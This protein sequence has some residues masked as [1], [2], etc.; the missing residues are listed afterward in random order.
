MAGKWD[1]SDGER[2][3]QTQARLDSDPTF[4]AAFQPVG[5]SAA[6][7]RD[8]QLTTAYC[9]DDN[10]ARRERAAVLAAQKGLTTAQVALK[11]L[12]SQ[13]FNAFVQVGTTSSKH[14]GE[15]SIGGSVHKLSADEVSWLETGEDAYLPAALAAADEPAEAAAHG[16][17]QRKQQS[18]EESVPLF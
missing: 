4:A 16:K 9:T 17:R 8:H 12:A 14:F 15:N 10:F 5:D 3:A 6:D 2:A 13:P 11:Y 7:W 1:R 18:A